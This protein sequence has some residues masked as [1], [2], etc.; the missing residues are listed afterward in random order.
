MALRDVSGVFSRE[1]IVGYFAPAFFTMWLVLYSAD[2]PPTAYQRAGGADRVLVVGAV[3][4][5]VALLL[6]GLKQPIL[7]VAAGH[8]VQHVFPV[9]PASA[10]VRWGKRQER[11]WWPSTWALNRQR[12]QW[13]DLKK[14]SESANNPYE[15]RTALMI[16]H[17]RL[18]DDREWL[19]STR[20][21]NARLGASQYS[22]NRWF[23]EVW[24][25]WP[26]IWPLLTEAERESQRDVNTDIAFFLNGAILAVGVG[27]FSI[28]DEVLG[29]N[30]S[31]LGIA[32][33]ALGTP[34]TSWLMYRFAAQAV[35]SSA[36]L[37]RVAFDLHWREF[38]A[39][40]G[41]P[42]DR[43]LEEVGRDLEA[44]WLDGEHANW[45]KNFEGEPSEK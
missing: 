9:F 28:I 44:F 24:F 30:T 19:R 6:N 42:P 31:W 10:E 29:K 3:A 40:I 5:L 43:S 37:Q 39:K 4:L 16:R 34:T 26:R 21:G 38:L 15:R 14:W 17:A 20:L 1:F 36:L 27:S 25:A 33:I 45:L 8:R 22:K 2:S 35:E 32:L 41:A 7:A 11:R 23:I 18:G 13:D 12:L